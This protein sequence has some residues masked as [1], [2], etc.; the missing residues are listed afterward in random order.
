MRKVHLP[1]AL[2]ASA[3]CAGATPR[4]VPCAGKKTSGE[5][6]AVLVSKFEIA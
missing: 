4:L 2:I 1:N 5:L 6:N 3:D